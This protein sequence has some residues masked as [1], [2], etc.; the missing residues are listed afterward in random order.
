VISAEAIPVRTLLG[1]KG[2]ET[3]CLCL[4]SLVEYSA[5]PVRLVIHEDGT[6][7]EKHRDLLRQ[8]SPGAEFIN[9]QAADEAVGER[10][11][12]HPYCLQFRRTEIMALK[13]FDIMLLGQGPV[14]YCDSDFLFLRRYRGLF[15]PPLSG[16]PVFMTDVGHAY[17]VRP[18]KLWPFG[19]IRLVGRLNAGLTLA[20]AGY[21]DLAFV[22]WLLGVLATD[23]VFVRRRYWTEQTCWAALAARTGADLLDP[24]QVVMAT[25]T[26]DGYSEDAVAVHFVATHRDQLTAYEGCKRPLAEEAVLV[27]VRPSRRIG[28]VRMFWTDLW[29]RLSP[30][31]HG[32]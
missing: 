21:L 30:I 28:P 5:D 17:A 32:R 8:I 12:G 1:A 19:P 22:E 9:R 26:M 29:R 20:P 7:T 24:R 16:R 23:P 11:A 14:A 2:F 25:R 10:L 4:R 13:L 31:R 18:W 6:L 15:A 27:G 3:S